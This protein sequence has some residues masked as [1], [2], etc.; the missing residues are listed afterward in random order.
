[1]IIAGGWA[2]MCK[3]ASEHLKADVRKVR[4][5]AESG[6][7]LRPE[8]GRSFSLTGRRTLRT[9]A[10]GGKRTQ[11]PAQFPDNIRLLMMW[12]MFGAGL[13]LVLAGSAR[14]QTPA[15]AEVLALNGKLEAAIES[16]D[17]ARIAPFFAPEFRLQNSANE[18]LSGDRVLAQFASGALRFST[19]ERN[20]EAHYQ[21]GDVVVLMGSEAVQRATSA[22]ASGSRAERVTRRFTSVWRRFPDGWKQIARQS[23]NVK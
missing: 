22:E 21:S 2:R 17:P 8:S 16:G 23:T 3:R 13:A 11:G 15:V 9:S 1:M 12:H 6:P 5:G 7:W 10:M 14:A 19:Y 4:F 20:I 18:I